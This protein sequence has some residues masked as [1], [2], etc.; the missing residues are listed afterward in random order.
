MVD[1]KMLL[2]V[3]K[4][5]GA[6]AHLVVV[7]LKD[8]EMTAALAAFPELRIVGEFGKRHRPEAELVIHLHHSRSGSDGED[9]RIGEEP[10]GEQESLLLDTFCNSHTAKGV[11]D[12]KSRVGDKTFPSPGFYI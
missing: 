12:D 5:T 3:V 10:P 2:G 4:Q 6:D 8:V 11:G 1:F 9:F 7:A